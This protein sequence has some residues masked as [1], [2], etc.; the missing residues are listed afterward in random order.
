MIYTGKFCDINNKQYTVRFTCSGSTGNQAVTMGGVPFVTAVNDADKLLYTPALYESATVELITDSYL[1]DLYTG[2]AQGVKV[3]LIDNSGAAVWVGYVEP[4][5]Y[6]Q[7][8]ARDRET[9]QVNCVSALASLRYLKFSVTDRAATVSFAQLLASVIGR[10][11]AYTDFYVSANIEIPDGAASPMEAAVISLENFYK[12]RSDSSETDNDLAWYCREVLEEICRYWGLTAIASGTS[13]YLIDYDAI[14]AGDRSAW[15]YRV[16]DGTCL[17]K[18]TMPGTHRT[19]TAADHAADD[20]ALSMEAVYDKVTVTDDYY[21]ME[22]I[23]IDPFTDTGTQNITCADDP[24]GAVPG[25]ASFA[26]KHG[27]L[28]DTVE[29]RFSDED[30]KPGRVQ[31]LFDSVYAVKRDEWNNPNLVVCRWLANPNGY[32]KA[33]AVTNG[34]PAAATYP[35]AMGYTTAKT[36]CGAVLA[37]FSVQA[38]PWAFDIPIFFS[39]PD[40]NKGLAVQ[41]LFLERTDGGISRFAYDGKWV[42]ALGNSTWYT[43]DELTASAELVADVHRVAAERIG[44]DSIKATNAICFFNPV[45]SHINPDRDDYDRLP[46]F[47]T[48]GGDVRGGL[49]GGKNAYL[50]I[51]GNFRWHYDQDSGD[52]NPY[53]VPSGQADPIGRKKKLDRNYMYIPANEC[54]TYAF[55]RHGGR[56]WNGSRWVSDPT[57]DVVFKLWYFDP[58]SDDDAR[59]VPNCMCADIP[60]RNNINYTMGLGSRKGTAIPLPGDGSLLTS[61]PVFGMCKIHDPKMWYKDDEGPHYYTFDRVFLTDLKI[62]IATG[63]ELEADPDAEVSYTNIIDEANAVELEEIKLRITT[64]EDSRIAY[65]NVGVL[66]K[67]GALHFLGK[68]TNKALIATERLDIEGCDGG[69]RQEE[70]LVYKLVRQYSQPAR[71]LKMTVHDDGIAM[72][73]TYAVGS[74]GTPATYIVRGVQR[75]YRYA[76]AFIN[77]IEKF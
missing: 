61:A 37:Q 39:E 4:T 13:V 70:H 55:L 68:T 32:C 27:A 51:S 14:K 1:P 25:P 63:N 15:H 3:E 12:K 8:Y 18:V 11:N 38:T 66:D 24:L 10:C 76:E 60:I 44:I 65:S 49:A 57:G 46:F 17:G 6:S 56:S 20:T 77:L 36:F 5:I 40:L 33:Y 35:A 16:S 47:S 52:V 50:V 62:E 31:R 21:V 43:L 53:P 26:I 54:W 67:E 23:T 7:G 73:D 30:K 9:V 29:L 34:V 64:M 74:A 42:D 2:Q 75:D 48:A 59:T 71:S 45:A 19:L 22:E 58:E 28:L 69:L 41:S 72:T